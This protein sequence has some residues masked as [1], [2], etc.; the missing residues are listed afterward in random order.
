MY[1]MYL[2]INHASDWETAIWDAEKKPVYYYSKFLQYTLHTT[3]DIRDWV[4]TLN[5]K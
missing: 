1:S 3:L 5:L 4:A 2:L